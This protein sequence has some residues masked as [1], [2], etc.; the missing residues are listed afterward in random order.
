MIKVG[1]IGCGRIMWEGHLP[2]YKH[3][4]E[5]QI[6]AINDVS[7][8]RLS[9]FR[10]EIN[11]ERKDCYLDYQ[12]ML[13]REDIDF[14]DI[15]VPHV[16]HR[17]VVVAASEAGKHVLCE[18]PLA[19]T[20]RDTDRMIKA[21]K[22]N[23]VKLGVFHNY[24]FFPANTKVREIIEGGTI[25][26]IVFSSI[27]ALGI[28]Y[29]SGVKEYNSLWRSNPDY[30]GGGVLI[31]YGVHPLYLTRS[32]F[33][34]ADIESVNSLVDSLGKQNMG[35]EDFASC[36]LE[37][38]SSYG[39]VNV[40]WGK[41]GTGG[42]EITGEKGSIKFVYKNGEGAPH[43]ACK[44]IYVRSSEEESQI[45]LNL[46]EDSPGWLFKGAI[47]DF[48][49][50]V[51]ENREPIVTGED[52]RKVV[53][54]VLASYESAALDKTMKLPLEKDDPVYIKGVEGLKDLNI[55]R[56]NVMRKKKLFGIK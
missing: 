19:T 5:V 20:L 32:F 42:T 7:E 9:L 4:P 28:G 56:D 29:Y 37:F 43:C 39:I 1:L 17:E 15:S 25:G 21:A 46:D 51:S 31:D 55:P 6:A 36:K 2:A 27:N 14:V 24:L 53:E 54:V 33:N 41:G 44:R 23:K 8:E 13:R 18:K 16:L 38:S 35:V 22:E 45:N 3:I 12:K 48:I 10:K 47:L 34:N 30:S 52:G 50:S 26:K 40:C 49:N 11:L